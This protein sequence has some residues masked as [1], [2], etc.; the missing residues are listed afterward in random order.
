MPS[1]KKS[2]PTV[3]TEQLSESV[4]KKDTPNPLDEFDAFVIKC[5]NA[6]NISLKELKASGRDDYY[7]HKLRCTKVLINEFRGSKWSP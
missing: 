1:V 7:A 6:V 3:H 2:V 5:R 4:A